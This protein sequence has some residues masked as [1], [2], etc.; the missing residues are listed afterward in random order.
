MNKECYQKE[1]YFKENED[2][3]LSFPTRDWWEIIP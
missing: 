3:D 1:M 2:S